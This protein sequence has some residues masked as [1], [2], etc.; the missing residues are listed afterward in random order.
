[1]MKLWLYAGSDSKHTYTAAVPLSSYF[2][3][4]EFFWRQYISPHLYNQFHLT[5]DNTTIGDLSAIC[6]PEIESLL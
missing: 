2:L 5:T 3:C 1:M 4:P 6:S